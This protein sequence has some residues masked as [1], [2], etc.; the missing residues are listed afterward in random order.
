MHTIL[1]QKLDAAGNELAFTTI[2]KSLSYSKEFDAFADKDA[3]QRLL[4]ALSAD[5]EGQRLTDPLQVY[6]TAVEFKYVVIDPRVVFSILII[7][8]FLMDIAVR[9]FKW[10]W[11]HE[12]I[13]D[14]KRKKTM[15]K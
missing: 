3:A 10:K 11:P 6:E 12:W 7:S 14:R 8:C 15:S 9:K 2:Y 4:D 1:V 13:A 5:T